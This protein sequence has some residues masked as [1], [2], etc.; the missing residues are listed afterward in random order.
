MDAPIVGT[1]DRLTAM[2]LI[3]HEAAHGIIDWEADPLFGNA[4]IADAD[5]GSTY[6][7]QEAARSCS[8]E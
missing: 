3:I 5:M 6:T 8:V 2:D 7:A 1:N 4:L